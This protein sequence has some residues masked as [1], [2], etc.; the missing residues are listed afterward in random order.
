[1]IAL[2]KVYEKADANDGKRFLIERLW[3]R[4]MRKSELKF[5]AWIKETGPS[6][7]LRR[8]FSHDP[9]RWNEFRHR[10]FVELDS[11][12]E[13]WEPILQAASQGHVTLLFSSHDVEHNNAVALSEYLLGKIGKTNRD[14]AQT[15]Q[16]A[17]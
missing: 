10:Y 17:A 15:H 1:M 4:G 2:K 6:H 14:S 8:W 3:P 7:D 16:H 12:P 13:A 11:K 5:D 9:A